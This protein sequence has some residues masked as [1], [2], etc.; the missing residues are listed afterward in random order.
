MRTLY[1]TQP[2]HLKSRILSFNPSGCTARA[3]Q[4]EAELA[5]AEKKYNE[6][7]QHK[8]EYYDSCVFLLLNVFGGGWLVGGE[9]I[10]SQ[11]QSRSTTIRGVGWG[12]GCA[13]QPSRACRNTCLKGHSWETKHIES[14][15]C[16]GI[17]SY[18]LA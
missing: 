17:L 12:W 1:L 6:S 8:P 11:Q 5:K 15:S 16:K 3:P 4:V 2:P 9:F 18:D 10:K 13:T 14:P 7:L